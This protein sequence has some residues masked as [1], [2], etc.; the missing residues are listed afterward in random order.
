[1]K[2]KLPKKFYRCESGDH[3][4]IDEIAIIGI[5][6]IRGKTVNL[7]VDLLPLQVHHMP[8][9]RPKKTDDA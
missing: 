1:M 6:Q 7:R 3:I 2:T 4:C 8:I 5:K 9:K